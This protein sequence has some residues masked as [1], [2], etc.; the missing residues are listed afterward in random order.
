[1]PQVPNAQEIVAPGRETVDTR[2]PTERGHAQAVPPASGTGAPGTFRVDSP[3]R[4]PP[5]WRF[6]LTGLGPLGVMCLIAAGV[7]LVQR[8]GA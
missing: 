1:M 2:M 7:A 8:F 5:L 4:A 3:H 6:A